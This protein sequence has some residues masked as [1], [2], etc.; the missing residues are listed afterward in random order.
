MGK[1]TIC[2]SRKGKRNCLITLTFICSAC[3]GKSRKDGQCKQCSFY[4]SP[5]SECKFNKLL[6]EDNKKIKSL[7]AQGKIVQA[8]RL[9]VERTGWGLKK[10]KDYVDALEKSSLPGDVRMGKFSNE[11][12]KLV[13]DK[14]RQLVVLNKKIEAIQLVHHN[15]EMGLKEAKDYIDRLALEHSLQDN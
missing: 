6:I 2:N 12:D 3:C 10:S 7:L 9:V 14:A 8:V 15:T 13:A 5:R 11:P 1:C 4:Q